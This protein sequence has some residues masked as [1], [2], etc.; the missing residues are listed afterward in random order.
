MIGIPFTNKREENEV[1]NVSD[2]N[3]IGNG[4]FER[5]KF[6]FSF[7][8]FVVLDDSCLVRKGTKRR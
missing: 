2:D 5:S 1:L 3:A 4:S 6:E 7:I 8:D